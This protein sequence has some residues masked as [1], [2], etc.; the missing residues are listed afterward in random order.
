MRPW[1][2]IVA[3]AAICW[4]EAVCADFGAI[5]YSSSTGHYGWAAGQGDRTAAQAAAARECAR[6]ARDCQLAT[7]F[8]NACGALAVANGNGWGA[9]WDHNARRAESAALLACRRYDNTNC[10]IEIG[11]CSDQ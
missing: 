2:G 5:Y 11:F 9:G 10:R 4:A 3:L 1:P 6:Q 8:E 7:W